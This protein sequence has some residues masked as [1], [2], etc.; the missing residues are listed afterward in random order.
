[1]RRRGRRSLIE[2]IRDELD[3][4]DEEG[5]FYV[6]YDFSG[7]YVPKEFYLN[8][9]KIPHERLNYS[10]LEFHSLR[11]ALATLELIRHYNSKARVILVEV[12]RVITKNPLNVQ[13]NFL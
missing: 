10:V 4:E 3:V 13:G 9:K 8:L 5:V 12:K 11:D 2:K 7:R 6:V 1:M